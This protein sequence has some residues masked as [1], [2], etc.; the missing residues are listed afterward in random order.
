MKYISKNHANSNVK[1][2]KHDLKAD[3][4]GIINIPEI[5]DEAE[6]KDF[7][8]R[9]NISGFEKM[10][11]DEASEVEAS[12]PQNDEEIEEEIEEEIKEEIKEEVTEA[13]PVTEEEDKPKFA[14]G[15]NKNKKK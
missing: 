10:N 12:E 3:S 14:R 1:I 4:Q 7:F 11:L 13:K 9:L 8:K 15:K 5:K 6:S 2:G